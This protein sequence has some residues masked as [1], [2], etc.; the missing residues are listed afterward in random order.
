MKYEISYKVKQILYNL[1]CEFGFKRDSTIDEIDYKFWE[2]VYPQ[3]IAIALAEKI[4][5]L[6]KIINNG[7]F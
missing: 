4:V 5:E 1:A 6:N 2:D 7:S 3:D